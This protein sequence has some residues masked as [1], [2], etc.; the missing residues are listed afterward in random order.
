[1]FDTSK[2]LPPMDQPGAAP[3]PAPPMQR[4]RGEALV[5]LDQRRGGTALARL[6]QAGAAK[7][8][9]PRIHGPVPEVVFLNTAGGLT[10]GDR[11]S[12]ALDLGAGTAATATTQ[13][14]E[15]AYAAGAG[16]AALEVRLRLG[17]GARADW[18]PQE[19]ILYD[20]AALSRR[21]RADLAPGARLVLAEMLVL[22]RA[23]MGE[24]VARLAL[25]DRREVWRG[26]EPVLIDPFALTSACLSPPGAA[27][28]SRLALLGG[29]RAVATLALVA[30]GAED[31]AGPLRAALAGIEAAEAAVSGWDG[32]C[33]VR[34]RAAGGLPLRRAVARA[35]HILRGGAALPR[36][37]QI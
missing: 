30:D 15:R 13:T 26:S 3:A 27:R 1:M 14:A 20:A 18:L 37:W 24:A 25:S 21:T 9:L 7:A 29:A 28:V 17:P 6:A 5:A 8:F 16:R 4:A 32:R 35:L 11:L 19:T 2:P 31:A 10:G 23:A 12:Y 33:L 36:V 22:G 34:I